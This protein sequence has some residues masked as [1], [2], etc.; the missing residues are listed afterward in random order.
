ML[1]PLPPFVINAVMD[2]DEGDEYFFYRP[3]G[4]PKTAITGWQWRLGKVYDVAA[5]KTAIRTDSVIRFP[6]TC[7]RAL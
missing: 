5:Q 2:C 1:V 7:S 6:W 4:T 3:S